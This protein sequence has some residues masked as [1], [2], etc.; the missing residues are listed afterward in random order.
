[1]KG[2]YGME[3]KQMVVD[4]LASDPANARTHNARNIEAV[5]SSLLRFGQQ[6]PIVID[7][8]GIVRAGNGTLAAAKSLGWET[9]NVVQT[10]LDGVEATAYAIADNRT[11]ELA[12][13]DDDALA[14]QLAAIQIQ[15]GE[16]ANAAGFTDDEIATMALKFEPEQEESR[17]DQ[18]DEKR[19]PHCGEQ[20]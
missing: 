17:L 2:K 12:S 4:E 20:L 1:M 14:E 10:A 15:D 8:N 5:K 18:Q 7:S 9:I 3:I 11:A 13:W 6:K 16:L 19:C